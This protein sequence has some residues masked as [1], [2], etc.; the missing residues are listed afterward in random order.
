MTQQESQT[1]L[2]YIFSLDPFRESRR[3]SLYSDFSNAIHRNPEGFRANMVAWKDA[4]EKACYNGHWHHKLYIEFNDELRDSLFST[5]YGRPLSLGAV[6]NY[7]LDQGDWVTK[8][9][10]KGSVQPQNGNGSIIMGVLRWGFRTLGFTT[11][12]EKKIPKQTYPNGKLFL[13]SNL[14]NLCISIISEAE[15]LHTSYSSNIYSYPSFAEIF[16][17]KLWAGHTLDEDELTAILL[18][19]S[20]K[21]RRITYDKE[22]IKFIL[23]PEEELLEQIDHSIAKLRQASFTTSQRLESLNDQIEKLTF[24]LKECLEQK[25]KKSALSLLRKRHFL[26]SNVEQKE[27]VLLQLDSLV[28]KIDEALDNRNIVDALST[29]AES[30]G[31]ILRSMGGA[32]NVDLILQRVEEQT[33]VADE[34]A[35]SLSAA[36]PLQE[37]EDIEKEWN[38]LVKEEQKEEDLVSLLERTSLRSPSH[39]ITASEPE[40]KNPERVLEPAMQS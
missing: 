14:Q 10:L 1:L 7:W 16:G 26:F 15:R 17:K 24:K 25:K 11:S 33:Q 35:E 23:T 32:T 3:R 4:L 2:K 27:G 40:V 30:L 6:A 37:D 38:K 22:V 12:S 19:L 29:G 8:N 9:N 21:Y 20:G 34:I 39:P 36:A 28:S 13:L 5:E 18:Y 31:S